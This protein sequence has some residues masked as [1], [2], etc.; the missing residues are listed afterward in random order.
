LGLYVGGRLYT[1]NIDRKGQEMTNTSTNDL[2]MEMATLAQIDRLKEIII[3]KNPNY[4][5]ETVYAVLAGQ[6]S[7][8]VSQKAIERIIYLNTI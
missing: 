3:E 4:S 1:D 2:P 8:G 6:L 5:M 7:V